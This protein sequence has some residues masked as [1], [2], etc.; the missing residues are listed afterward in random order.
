MPLSA[1]AMVI[2]AA[3]LHALWNIVAKMTG[4]L[5]MGGGVALLAL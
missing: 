2:V 5:L 3:L 1:L 4:A